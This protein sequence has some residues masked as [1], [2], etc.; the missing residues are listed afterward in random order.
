[1][2]SI[3]ND[4]EKRLPPLGETVTCPKCQQA[5]EVLYG[6]NDKGE[7]S[8]LLGFYKCGDTTY[9]AGINGKDVTNR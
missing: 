9:L 5:H 3:S 4:E 6:T 2:F 7:E 8:R 1:M